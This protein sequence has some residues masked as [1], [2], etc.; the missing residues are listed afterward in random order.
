MGLPSDVRSIVD[1]KVV[2]RR[3]PV[4]VAV[5]PTLVGLNFIL[6]RRRGPCVDTR[7]FDAAR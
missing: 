6:A 1:R 3:I 2:M 4:V 5:G 7:I